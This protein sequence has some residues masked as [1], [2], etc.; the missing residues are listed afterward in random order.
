MQEYLDNRACL[1]WLIDP[2]TQQVEIYRPRQGVEVPQQ[3]QTLSGENVLPGFGLD[4]Q[5]IFRSM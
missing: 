3:P 1:G 4:L 2:K 5:P